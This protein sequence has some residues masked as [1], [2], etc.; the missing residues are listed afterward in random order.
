MLNLLLKLFFIIFYF[1]LFSKNVFSQSVFIVVEDIS[2]ENICTSATYRNRHD[3]KI[4]FHQK[5]GFYTTLDFGGAMT[6]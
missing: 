4:Y 1:F 2:D 6:L 3:Q 5:I